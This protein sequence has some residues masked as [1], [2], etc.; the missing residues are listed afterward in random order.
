[1]AA[2]FTTLM[3]MAFAATVA[4]SFSF[5]V[6]MTVA[7]PLSMAAVVPF[8]RRKIFSMETFSKFLLGSIPDGEDCPF[9]IQGFSCHAVV[10]VH[11][12]A[13]IGNFL[14]GGV[15]YSSILPHHGKCPSD[16]HKV[17]SYNSFDGKSRL[18]KLKH[19]TL[20]IRTVSFFGKEGK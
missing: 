4:A 7:L 14:Y 2:A 5:F 1:M 17:L 9:E 10:E 13:I 3:A 11:Y 15:E 20:V 16:F 8:F 12:D 6:L 18:W 19:L